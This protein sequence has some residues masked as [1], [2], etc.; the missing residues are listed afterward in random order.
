M[1]TKRNILI[2]VDW[3]WPG[4]L[5]GGPVQSIMSLVDYLG[6]DFNFK[7]ITTNCDLNSNVPYPEITPNVWVKSEM[8]CEIYYADPK[9]LSTGLIK[10]IIAEV[11]F[12][13]VYINSFFS[14]FFS[15]IPLQI[16]NKDYPNKPIILAPRGMLGDGAL[17]LKKYKKKVFIMYSKLSGLHSTVIWHATSTQ[18]EK[19]IVKVFNP[20]TPIVKISNLPKKVNAPL[21]RQKR[22]GV[23]NLCFVSRISEK[24][25]LFF[26]LEILTDIKEVNV[27]YN[28][29]GP[30]ED[31]AYWEKCK[32]QIRTMPP[33][34]KVT[35]K[36]SLSPDAIEKIYGQEEMMFLPTLNENFGHS[37]VESLL[38]GCPVIISDQTPWNDL[39]ESDAGYAISLD[40]KEKF[41]MVII[42]CAN[43]NQDE[44][45]EKSKRAINYIAKKIDLELIT[46]QYKTLFNEPTKN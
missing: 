33:N 10:K 17:A 1:S 13:K 31:L 34:I 29:Y 3:F 38:C 40:N 21:T 30:L 8:G 42:T 12:D 18:E 7:I 46:Q 19:E 2:F 45:S 26:A 37:I 27:N 39:E 44:F 11:R 4:Y 43:L 32:E 23:L 25:N 16:L 9:T 28:I 14:K 5:A 41:K 6:V 15:I 36:G 35:Y 20:K 24:K 22:K